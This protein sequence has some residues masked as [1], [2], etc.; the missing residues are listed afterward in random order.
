MVSYKTS[1]NK[2]IEQVYCLY[3]CNNLF[4]II[5]QYTAAN[6]VLYIKEII[7]HINVVTELPRS[8][9]P[10]RNISYE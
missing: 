9:F 7:H 1:N 6:K 8:Y 5:Y 10:S 3:I 2:I 4:S